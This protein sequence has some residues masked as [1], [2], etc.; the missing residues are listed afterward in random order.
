MSSSSSI[1]NHKFSSSSS[2][3]PNATTASSP[4]P[5]LRIMFTGVVPTPLLGKSVS[6]ELHRELTS[7]TVSQLKFRILDQIVSDREAE[8]EEERNHH[9]NKNNNN[10]NHTNNNNNRQNVSSSL[11]SLDHHHRHPHS[12][13]SSSP[14]QKIRIFVSQA[15]IFG[16]K[17]IKMGFVLEDSQHLMKYLK[18]P[19]PTATG[20]DEFPALTTW[21][22][23]FQDYN[24]MIQDGLEQV[25]VY[26]LKEKQG[27]QALLGQASEDA[28]PFHAGDISEP[29]SRNGGFS[30]C[31]IL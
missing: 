27:L 25:D 5:C 6:F 29:P 18:N 23:V 16:F 15:K 13:D 24:S 20:E 30:C 21:H 12:S 26:G 7:L 9:T 28:A 1:V 22:A 19:I 8:E 3:S 31:Q 10:S 11:S 17:L 14:S 2:A 4:T